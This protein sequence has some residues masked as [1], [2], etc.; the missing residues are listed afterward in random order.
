MPLGKDASAPL[1]SSAR[2]KRGRG[3]GRERERE[4]CLRAC[5]CSDHELEIF[6]STT[7]PPLSRTRNASGPSCAVT[8]NWRFLSTAGSPTPHPGTPPPGP[9]TLQGRVS[10]CR[11]CV[12]QRFAQ[13]FLWVSLTRVFG[14]YADLLYFAVGLAWCWSGSP[15]GPPR[16]TPKSSVHIRNVLRTT[17]FLSAPKPKLHSISCTPMQAQQ[18]LDK[19]SASACTLMAEPGMNLKKGHHEQYVPSV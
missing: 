9:P 2:R 19:S 13:R 4:E 1:A 10:S 8:R 5:L 17:A 12:L 15:L 3:R 6:G 16:G 14:A 11:G 18:E 7:P